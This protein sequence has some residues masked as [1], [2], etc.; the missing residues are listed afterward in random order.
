MYL[1]IKNFDY[2]KE[3]LQKII[4]KYKEL[5]KTA[6]EYEKNHTRLLKTIE[7]TLNRLQYFRT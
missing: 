6:K 4:F 2:L 5:C 3:S 1:F 7:I